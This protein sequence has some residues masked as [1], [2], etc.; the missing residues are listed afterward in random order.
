LDLALIRAPRKTRIITESRHKG[1]RNK[2]RFERPRDTLKD[3]TR[4]VRELESYDSTKLLL[5]DW[6]VHYNCVRPHMSLDGKTPA[7]A[8]RM[9][10]L[11]NWKRV[12]AQ[13]TKHEASMLVNVLTNKVSEEKEGLKSG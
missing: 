4:C 12:I 3:R 11:N 8:A 6:S 7:Q 9:D 1:K 2:Q 10:I 5:E 13:A